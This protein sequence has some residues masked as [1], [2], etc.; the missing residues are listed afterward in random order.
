M[1]QHPSLQAVAAAAAIHSEPALR[2]TLED[3]LSAGVSKE[4]LDRTIETA[5]EIAAE[6]VRSEAK[7]V[8]VEVLARQAARERWG[9]PSP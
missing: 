2:R 8:L 7:R 9:M 4:D 5:A 1:T 6:A 3:A